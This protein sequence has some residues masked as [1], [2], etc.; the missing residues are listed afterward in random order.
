MGGSCVKPQMETS[1]GAETKL[2]MVAWSL[3]PRVP[4]TSFSVSVSSLAFTKALSSFPEDIKQIAGLLSALPQSLIHE[5][6]G[7]VL[8]A[9]QP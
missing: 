1:W 9:Q 2:W 3:L 7:W 8:P 5:A 6:R 4:W